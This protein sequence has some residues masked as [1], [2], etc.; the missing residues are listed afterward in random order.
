MLPYIHTYGLCLP[1]LPSLPSLPNAPHALPKR[2][3]RIR[4]FQAVLRRSKTLQNVPRRF[5]ALPRH[6]QT[7]P[8]APKTLPNTPQYF[9]MPIL[10]YIPCIHMGLC[11]PAC[12]AC[13]TLPYDPK[14]LEMHSIGSKTLKPIPHSLYAYVYLHTIPYHMELCLPYHHTYRKKHTYVIGLAT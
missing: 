14:A 7:I 12:L 4:K 10:T 13:Q 3:E 1:S 5:Q 8:N 2:S 9:I 11:C 6:F